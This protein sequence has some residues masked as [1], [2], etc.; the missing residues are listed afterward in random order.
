MATN[1]NGIAAV[2]ICTICGGGE[3]EDLVLI[4]DGPGCTSEIHMYCLNPPVLSVPPAEWF[5]PLCNQDEGHESL[6]ILINSFTIPLQPESHDYNSRQL[7]LQQ[8]RIP[9][10]NWKVFGARQVKYDSEFDPKDDSLLGCLVKIKDFASNLDY[11]GRIISFRTCSLYP[12]RVEHLIHFKRYFNS[13]HLISHL[14][15]HIKWSKYE[16]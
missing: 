9:L 3:D 4:C 5:C 16:K 6:D 7:C 12:S 15:M 13:F 11:S 14:I 8:N 1:D 10:K 2:T